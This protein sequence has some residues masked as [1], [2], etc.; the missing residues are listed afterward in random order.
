MTSGGLTR[1]ENL[2]LPSYQYFMF[3][4][5]ALLINVYSTHVIGQAMNEGLG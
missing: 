5:V 2:C 4:N 3:Q 1:T